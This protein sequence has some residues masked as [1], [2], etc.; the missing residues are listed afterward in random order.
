VERHGG[1]AIDGI[2]GYDFIARHVIALD[3]AARTLTA[4]DPGAFAYRRRGTAVPITLRHNHP[5]VQASLEVEA[6]VWIAGDF[7]IDIGSRLAVALT[8]PFVSR[9]DLHRRLGPTVSSDIGR[10]VGGGARSEVGQARALRAGDWV[11]PLP[12]V[13]MFGDG[14]GVFTSGDYFEG[15]IGAAVL[16]RY[17]LFIDYGRNRIIFERGLSIT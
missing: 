2:L 8:K 11:H 12:A 14:A 15:N 17:R 4:Y 1:R 7:V 9:H 13:A 3:Y 5:H 16:E 10:G 6:G